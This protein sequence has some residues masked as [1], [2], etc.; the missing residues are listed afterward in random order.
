MNEVYNGEF[1]RLNPL[2]KW[3]DEQ[4]I[5]LQIS[6]LRNNYTMTTDYY[7]SADIDEK[8]QTYWAIKLS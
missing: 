6:S 8:W 2:F 5:K 3:A 4:K 1:L 7:I